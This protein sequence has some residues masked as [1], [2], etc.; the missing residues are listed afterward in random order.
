MTVVTNEGTTDIWPTFYVY[1][2]VVVFSITNNSI[3]DEFGNPPIF[4]Y[5]PLG[6]GPA[7]V[8]PGGDYAIVDMFT[9]R[10]ELASDGSDLTSAVEMH[11]SDFFPL[12]PGPNNITTSF[13]VTVELV[14]PVTAWA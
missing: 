10:I 5:L 6:I 3:L 14:R 4:S 1:G 7:G 8:I 12:V 11:L 13:G 2:P 9:N